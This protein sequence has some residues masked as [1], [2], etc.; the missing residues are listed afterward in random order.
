MPHDIERGLRA[1]FFRYM[2]K[3]IKV[4]EFMATLDSALAH[5]LT[6]QEGTPQ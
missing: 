1:G 5:A 3:P 2:T 6:V 4:G